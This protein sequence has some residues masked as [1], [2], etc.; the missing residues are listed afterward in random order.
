M[1]V[2]TYDSFVGET[3]LSIDLD[4]AQRFDIAAYGLAGEV[5]S[6]VAAIKKRLLAGGSSDALPQAD[7]EIVE[8]LGDVMW[9]CFSL[10]RAA[11]PNRPANI[12]AL[13]I[14]NLRR[15]LTSVNPRL[16]KISRVLDRDKLSDFI[17]NSKSFSRRARK[18]EFEDYQKLAF[19]TARTEGRTL[20][21]VCLAVLWQLSA[22]LLRHKLPQIERELNVAL[23]DRPVNDLLG[24][25]A[26]HVAALA[27]LFGLRLS[28]V[29]EANMKKV[30]QRWQRTTVTPL[31]DEGQKPNEQFPRRF[32]VAFVSLGPGRSRMY[33]DGRS[34]LGDDLTDNSYDEDGYRYHDV[35]HL[36]NV[37]KLGWSPVLRS[38]MGRKRKS[39]PIVDEVEDGARARIVEEAVIKAI[40]SE[41]ER[42]AS[43]RYGPDTVGTNRLFRSGADI[44]FNFLKFVTSFVAD[45]EV[46]KNRYSEWE[47][48]IVEGY[49]LFDKLSREGQ[50][51]VAVDLDNRSL[52]F[53]PDVFLGIDGRVAGLGTAS[54]N[55]EPSANEES[56]ENA[57]QRARK[58]AILDALGLKDQE[59]L[60]AEL[61]LTEDVGT[62][63]LSVRGPTQVRQAMW[64]RRVVTFRASASATLHGVHATAIAISD[65]P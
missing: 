27:T 54:E 42:L 44:S 15:E 10:A 36:A 35:M 13:D 49:D 40:H 24:E 63:L 39:D 51:T 53:S 61:H 4:A 19:L 55:L 3:D 64:D 11:N 6:V 25:I 16:D 52:T 21:R 48:A 33:L 58:R 38:L 1:L 46:E 57:A 14:S 50:G 59:L 65:D 29:A 28:Q 37:A 34:R 8:E 43:L 47:A 62:R 30:T 26:W 45:L 60:V 2:S 18:M 31:H 56:R 17:N 32:E 12:F 5:G 22:Q 20:A 23:V 7:A 41:G 9:Y